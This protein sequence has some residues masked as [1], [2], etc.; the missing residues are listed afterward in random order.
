MNNQ[1]HFFKVVKIVNDDNNTLKTNINNLDKDL[2]NKKHQN[3]IESENDEFFSNFEEYNEED[4]IIDNEFDY[5]EIDLD[6]YI[7]RLL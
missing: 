6:I 2:Q 3:N 7:R 4:N 5:E 1:N